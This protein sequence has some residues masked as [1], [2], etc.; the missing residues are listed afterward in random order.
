MIG[1]PLWDTVGDNAWFV[2]KHE[3]SQCICVSWLQ[4]LT[5]NIQK[6]SQ[7]KVILY[8]F[9][10]LWPLNVTFPVM[11]CCVHSGMGCCP[12]ASE[13]VLAH[14]VFENRFQVLFFSKLLHRTNLQRDPS[15]MSVAIIIRLYRRLHHGKNSMAGRFHHC[16]TDT[17]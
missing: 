13:G 3:G 8:V 14:S 11:E 4:A 5:P 6:R 1:L 9:Q 17:F 16:T 15:D 2:T 12:T 10:K 7:N